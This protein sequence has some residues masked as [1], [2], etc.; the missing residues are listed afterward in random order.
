MRGESVNELDG[1][2]TEWMEWGGS[3]FRLP[4]AEISIKWSK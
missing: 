2:F 4:R 1:V 3:E